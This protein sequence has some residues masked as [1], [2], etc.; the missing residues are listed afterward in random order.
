MKTIV[1]PVIGQTRA[2]DFPVFSH[3]RDLMIIASTH[4]AGAPIRTLR[5]Q[6]RRKKRVAFTGYP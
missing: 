5:T 6:W 3:N 4:M 2:L 1:E